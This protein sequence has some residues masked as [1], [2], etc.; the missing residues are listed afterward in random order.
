MGH[1][2]GSCKVLMGIPEGKN[3]LEDRGIDGSMKMRWIFK[4]KAGEAGTRLIWLRIGTS[5]R[6]L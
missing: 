2:K 6:L 1:R 3:H 5:G 4:K